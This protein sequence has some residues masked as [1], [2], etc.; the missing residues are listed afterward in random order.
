MNATTSLFNALCVESKPRIT[1]ATNT[2]T[3]TK[4]H[5]EALLLTIR[6]AEQTSY[7]ILTAASVTRL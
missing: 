3:L 5:S 2:L 6:A 7:L 1:T 4:I